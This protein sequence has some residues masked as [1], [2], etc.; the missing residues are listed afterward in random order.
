MRC[1]ATLLTRENRFGVCSLNIISEKGEF[2]ASIEELRLQQVAFSMQVDLPSS[3]C[4]ASKSVEAEF[5]KLEVSNHDSWHVVSVKTDVQRTDRFRSYKRVESLA[6]V[7]DGGGDESELYYIISLFSSVPSVLAIELSELA[8]YV[9][10]LK[11]NCKNPQITVVNALEGS[12]FQC[13]STLQAFVK[14]AMLEG[15]VMRSVM[16]VNCEDA[17]GGLG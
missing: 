9:V 1:V 10:R 14:T 11:S 16:A 2:V 17:I 3:F 12:D 7:T 4:W 8:A 13:V 15:I 5:R 6:D